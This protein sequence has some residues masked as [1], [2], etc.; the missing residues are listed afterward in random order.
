[1]LISGTTVIDL[2]GLPINNSGNTEVEGNLNL[3]GVGKRITGDFSNATVSNRVL[4][5]TNV[6]N[7]N[8]GIWAMPNGTATCA[9]FG[10]SNSSDIN[11]AS[12]GYLYATATEVRLNSYANGTGTQL[13]L[14]FVTNGAERMRI[15][16][17]GNVGIGT[18]DVYGRLSII[19][20]VGIN[21]GSAQ[22][23]SARGIQFFIDGFKH[24]NLS[25]DNY[26]NL[27]Y[28]GNGLGYGTGAGGTVTQLTSK[29]TAVTLNK[30]SGQI[31]MSNAALAAGASVIFYLHNTTIGPS[32]IVVVKGLY[33]GGVNPQS[34]QVDT[35]ITQQNDATIM[36]KNISGSSLSESVV[37]NF[38]VIK[39][40]NA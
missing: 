39:G 13:P 18:T 6:N 5:Q 23:L 25:V 26:D 19:G 12:I 40:A 7:G 4:F 27:L 28:I 37:L 35:L 1:M 8:T 29:S 17:A 11:N 20:Q 24:G 14:S 2:T 30:P 22:A 36:V 34:Y 16:T 15:D 10:V 32:D 21:C 9:I 33:I 3:S 38:V 31:T